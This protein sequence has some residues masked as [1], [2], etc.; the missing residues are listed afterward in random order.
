MIMKHVSRHLPLS[1]T[2]V[3][4]SPLKNLEMLHDLTKRVSLTTIV[5]QFSDS[6]STVFN[7]CSYFSFYF[8][9]FEAK[10]K[11]FC[12]VFFLFIYFVKLLWDFFS[13][14][15]VKT[16]EKKSQSQSFITHYKLF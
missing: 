13:F 14:Y 6:T 2:I 15:G 16:R 12:K 10:L 7:V 3:S 8:W 9:F 11:W 4:N 1:N 5:H